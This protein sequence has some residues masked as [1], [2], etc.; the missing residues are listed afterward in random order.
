MRKINL[1][2]TTE[3]RGILRPAVRADPTSEGGVCQVGGGIHVGGLP[4]PGVEL[5]FYLKGMRDH[6]DIRSGAQVPL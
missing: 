5:G 3:G 4:R 6:E 1:N 2:P